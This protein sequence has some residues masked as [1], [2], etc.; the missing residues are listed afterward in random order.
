MKHLIRQA[1]RELHMDIEPYNRDITIMEIK[2]VAHGWTD[3]AEDHE[4]TKY[5]VSFRNRKGDDASIDVEPEMAYAQLV[6]SMT[7]AWRGERL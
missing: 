1:A 2:S 7:K 5:K 4:T 3:N 6:E